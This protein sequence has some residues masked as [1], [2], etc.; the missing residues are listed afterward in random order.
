MFR[1]HVLKNLVAQLRTEGEETTVGGVVVLT[2]STL[3]LCP[4]DRVAIGDRLAVVAYIRIGI[5]PLSELSFLR[6]RGLGFVCVVNSPFRRHR[7]LLLHEGTGVSTDIG[8]WGHASHTWQTA[9][10]GLPA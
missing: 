9:V 6:R 7:L 3:M 8:L 1:D 2:C 5:V 10:V 4:C